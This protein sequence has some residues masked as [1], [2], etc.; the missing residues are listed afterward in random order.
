MPV[1]HDGN[2]QVVLPGG[3]Q[4]SF[5]SGGS[6]AVAHVEPEHAQLEAVVVEQCVRHALASVPTGYR[7]YLKYGMT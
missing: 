1:S 7:L 5:G 6:A 4:V 3:L 2:I